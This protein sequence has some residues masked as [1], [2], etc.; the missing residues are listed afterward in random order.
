[1]SDVNSV[2]LSTEYFHISQHYRAKLDL[3]NNILY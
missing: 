3:G 2:K 1:M